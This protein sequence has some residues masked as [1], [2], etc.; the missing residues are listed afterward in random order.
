MR[1]TAYAP[2]LWLFTALVVFRVAGQL[3]VVL[4]RP[5]WLPP[6]EQW[7][8]GLV[9]YWFLLVSQGV[10][11]WLM[12]SISTQFTAGTGFW[13]DPHGWIGGAAYYWSYLYAGA[14]VARYIASMM[15]HPER[16]WS[17]HTIPIVFHTIVAAFQWTFGRYHVT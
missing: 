13:V 3:V 7:Q 2:Y 14:M 15:R 6:M 5:P 12:F 11:L 16:R 9:P 1:S 10:V 4:R 8:S 17:G